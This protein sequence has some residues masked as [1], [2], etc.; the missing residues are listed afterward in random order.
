MLTCRL[1]GHLVRNAR[2]LEGL[3]AERELVRNPKEGA[4]VCHHNVSC[5]IGTVIG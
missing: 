4:C 1:S 5:K 2:P 3:R